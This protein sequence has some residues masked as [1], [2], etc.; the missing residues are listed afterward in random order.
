MMQAALAGAPA[1]LGQP[2]VPAAAGLF[3]Q[4][5]SVESASIERALQASAG[6][7]AMAARLLGISPQLLHYKMKK[8]RIDKRMFLPDTL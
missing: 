7:V 2:K 5:Q 4:T 6:N 8:Y 3:A 1:A